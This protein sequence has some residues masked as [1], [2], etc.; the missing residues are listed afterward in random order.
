MTAPEETQGASSVDVTESE[1]RLALIDAAEARKWQL[2]EGGRYR[3]KVL[4]GGRGSG[5]SWEIAEDFLIIAQYSKCRFLCVREIQNSIRDSVWKL[6]KDTIERHHWDAIF[7]IQRETIICTKT[8]SE[9]I[10]K[11]LRLNTS[12]KSTEGIDYCWVEEAQ[13]VTDASWELLIPTIRKS[14]AEIWISYNPDTADTPVHKRFVSLPRDDALV[15]TVNWTENPFFPDVL[16]REMEYLYKVDPD[17][18]ANVW[19]GELRQ[20]TA[21]AIFHGKYVIEN[22]SDDLAQQ[23][24]RF[25]YGADHGFANDPATL[26]RCFI[27]NRRL[28]ID[29]EFWGI[30]VEIDELPRAYATVPGADRWPIYADCARPETNAYLSR[31]G[32]NVAGAEKWQ[33]SIEDGIAFIRSFEKVVIHTRC[34]HTADEFR[35]YSYKT[36]KITGQILPVIEDKFNHC[37]DA[38]RYALSDYIKMRG[39]YNMEESAKDNE[40]DFDESTIKANGGK[41]GKFGFEFA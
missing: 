27:L 38:V 8:G 26:I 14:N 18:A 39:G 29:Y 1:K 7:D 10:F 33:G 12:I 21:A 34:I 20:N 23:A 6:L 31:H 41:N 25:F 24:D 4:K 35:L 5:K 36:D 9:F 3:Y 19:G 40:N 2:L 32:F 11:G 13:Y 28:Y 16:R 22:F 30:G 17:A 37:I 15:L